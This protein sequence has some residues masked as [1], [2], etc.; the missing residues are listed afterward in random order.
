MEYQKTPT[1]GPGL[2]PRLA[3]S[4]KQRRRGDEAKRPGNINDTIEDVQLRRLA[5]AVLSKSPA[6]LAALAETNPQLFW[7]WIQAFTQKKREAEAAGQ[8][9]SAAIACLATV[10]T[11]EIQRIAAE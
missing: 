1:H 8:G 5:K 10:G 4:P 9:W 7:E 3:H 2:A 11:C 6:D